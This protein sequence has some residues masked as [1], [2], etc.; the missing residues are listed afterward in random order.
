MATI[1][2]NIWKFYKRPNKEKIWMG[3]IIRRASY[4]SSS[5]ERYTQ[6][7]AGFC[8]FFHLIN[9]RVLFNVLSICRCMHVLCWCVDNLVFFL[10]SYHNCM[11]H[12][13]ILQNY[14]I[15]NDLNMG[16]SC[17]NK[18]KKQCCVSLKDLIFFN[19][20]VFSFQS[21]KPIFLYY[22]IFSLLTRAGI[23]FCDNKSGYVYS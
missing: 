6:V 12:E 1:N 7:H 21:R 9:C 22:L 23:Y 11:T 20:L 10:F 16:L 18:E 3:L 2:V 8:S 13:K 19:G 14:G 4:H 17:M 5:I 15:N